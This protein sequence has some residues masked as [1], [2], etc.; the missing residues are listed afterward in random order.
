MKDF[1]KERKMAG[2]IHNPAKVKDDPWLRIREACK[3]FN[4]Q[5]VSYL[6][7]TLNH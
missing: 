1:E 6:P 7:K 2:K 5:M 4:F 3:E